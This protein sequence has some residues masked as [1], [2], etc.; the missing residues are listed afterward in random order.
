MEATPKQHERTPRGQGELLR[1]RLIDAAL[2]L[3][4][5]G[6]E[7]AEVSIRG[8]TRRA[9]VS[10]TAFYLH[11][12]SRGELL[13]ACVERIFADFRKRTR[14]AAS[15]GG[16]PEARLVNAGVA[17]IEFAREQ[18]ERY[19]LIFGSNWEEEGVKG[20]PE[21]TIDVA[22]AAF[23]DLVELVAAHSGSEDERSADPETL[24]LGIWS[25]MH[26]F[27]SLCNGRPGMAAPTAE[28]FATLLATAWLGPPRDS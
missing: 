9:G 4:D 8:V 20:G 10:P 1:E 15:G 5:E 3:L 6:A 11:F 23:T 21:D 19:G 24:A 26:G 28:E 27:V 14:A 7:P 22:A 18:P 17:Y 12:E 2:A 16:D 13:R 25:G